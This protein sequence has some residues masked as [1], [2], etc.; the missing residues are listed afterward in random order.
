MEHSYIRGSNHPKERMPQNV[1]NAMMHIEHYQNQ[2]YV[3]QIIT[4]TQIDQPT[5]QY[6]PVFNIYN[7]HQVS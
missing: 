4:A 1:D 3:E 2:M 5:Y 6:S 7:Q